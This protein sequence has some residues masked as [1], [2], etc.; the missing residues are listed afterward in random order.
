MKSRSAPAHVAVAALWLALLWW[1]FS[2]TFSSGG[3]LAPVHRAAW[4]GVVW[5]YIQQTWCPGGPSRCNW[6]G[7]EQDA[8]GIQGAGITWARVALRQNA[9][10]PFYD[11]LLGIAR[12]HGVMVL[13]TVYKS[14]PPN[15][16]GTAAQQVR[17]GRWLRAAVRRY[18]GT[19]RFWEIGNEENLGQSWRID[20]NA[21]GARYLAGV[22]SYVDFLK[23]SDRIIKEIDPRLRVLIGGLSESSMEPYLRALMRLGA[24]RWFDIL[25]VHPYA[26]TPEGVLE[27]LAALRRVVRGQPRGL[28]A[29]PIW[30][31]EVGFYCERGWQTT[32]LACPEAL[33]ARFLALT[34][35]RLRAA[36]IRTPIMWYALHE[37]GNYSGYGLVRIDVRGGRTTI[38]PAWTVYRRL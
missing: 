25:A 30:I 5:G 29:K 24:G 9:P 15:D 16:L 21:S 38:N 8:E 35:A 32:G 19:V 22:R 28:G 23:L 34:M 3:S 17:Y 37:A 11:R 14:D 12:A 18:T 4:K 6:A 33:K 1:A 26:P 31:T 20:V 36:G 13:F 7:I 27:R 10:F 2:V